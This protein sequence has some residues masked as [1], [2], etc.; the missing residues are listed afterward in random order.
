MGYFDAD[1]KEM[2]EV[3]MLETPSAAG[4][5][6]WFLLEAEKKHSFTESEIHAVFRIMHTIKGSSAMMRLSDLSRT[7]HKLE[8]LFSYYRENLGKIDDPEPELFDLLFAASDYIANELDD[9]AQESYQPR[10][11][12]TVEERAEAFLKTARDKKTESRQIAENPV[13]DQENLKE[14]EEKEENPLDLS[15]M[16]EGKDG[17]IVRVNLEPGCKMENIRAFMLVRQ[18]EE[19]CTSV[20]TYP[21][22]LDKAHAQAGYISQHGVIIRFESQEKQTVL[23][24]L[25]KGLFV[26][27]CEILEDRTVKRAELQAKKHEEKLQMKKGVRFSECRTDRRD[28]LQTLSEK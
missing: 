23:E 7:A 5:A 11:A 19:K 20:E 26:E 18:I 3:Y 21:D 8:D 15:E 4:A 16:F 17:M 9:M 12:A 25:G 2:L 10:T 28:A 6:G 24:M 22:H 14:L 1:E 13:E 27:S